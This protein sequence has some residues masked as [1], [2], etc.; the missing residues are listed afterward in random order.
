MT[1]S[2]LETQQQQHINLAHGWHYTSRR[3]WFKPEKISGPPLNIKTAFA[4]YGDSQVKD[5]TVARPSYLSH[6]DPHTGKTTSL[7]WN[8]PLNFNRRDFDGEKLISISI[9]CYLVLDALFLLPES[10]LA[11]CQKISTVQD[12][13]FEYSYHLG[14][15]QWLC[16]SAMLTTWHWN[17][18]CITCHSWMDSTHKRPLMRSFDGFFL[19]SLNTKSLLSVI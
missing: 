3:S 2:V 11:K 15:W 14:T 9:L 7:Y 6:G 4:G 5:K 12:Y 19:V 8:D 18:V 17:V 16:L 13:I 1:W 10:L